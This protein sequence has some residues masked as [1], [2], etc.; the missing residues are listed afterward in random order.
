MK[1]NI[2]ILIVISCLLSSCVSKRKTISEEVQIKTEEITSETAREERKTI[3]EWIKEHSGSVVITETEY[4]E[5]IDPIGGIKS[6]SN[7]FPPPK[8]GIKMERKTLV[9][10]N[11]TE[12]AKDV[13]TTEVITN[14]VA[15]RAEDTHR[16]TKITEKIK[17]HKS[18]VLR[19]I[20]II[21]VISALL[22]VFLRP[23]GMP[24]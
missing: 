7:V 21:F 3:S 23:L 14:K 13:E 20:I 2:I 15:A 11:T 16:E 12:Q 6:S 10:I 1:Q 9:K 5:P 17:D 24:R 19:Y 22:V 8:G 4:Y 18:G